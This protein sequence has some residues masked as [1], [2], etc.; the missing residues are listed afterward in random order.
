MSII[1][2][3]NPLH[4]GAVVASG[5]RRHALIVVI[6]VSIP[7]IAGQWSLHFVAHCR[8]SPL[9]GFQSPSLRGSGRFPRSPYGGRGPKRRFN[10]LHCGAVVASRWRCG[11]RRSPTCVSIPFIAGQW[12]LPLLKRL[13]HIVG[14]E[15]QSPSLRGSGRF[16]RT[17]TATRRTSRSF[18]PLHCGAVVASQTRHLFRP[19]AWRGF[20]PLH[21]GAVVASPPAAW[22]RGKEDKFQSPSLR[23]SGRFKRPPMRWFDSSFKFQSPSLRGSGRFTLVGALRRALPARFNPLHCGAVVASSPCGCRS[24]GEALVSIPFIAGQWSLLAGCNNPRAES[25][26]KF[27]SPSLRGS[28]R[29]SPTPDAPASQQIGFNP[30][31]C[32]AVVASDSS[33]HLWLPP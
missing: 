7:F 21:C 15:F 32:G 2:R 26:A 4:C 20:N 3:F 13:R 29:F 9:S 24:A 28:G 5:R 25:E 19:A 12:S 23:G 17:P 33:P 27:Q 30:L 18:N 10:P 14:N 31:H 8:P 22:R 11:G 1:S 6:R 16:P